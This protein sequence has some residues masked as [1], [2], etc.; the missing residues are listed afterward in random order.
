MLADD[1]LASGADIFLRT[2]DDKEDLL[3]A[4]CFLI[5]RSLCFSSA[6]VMLFVFVGQGQDDGASAVLLIVSVTL[7]TL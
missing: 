1:I 4:K 2:V 6:S 5:S 7:E 3:T